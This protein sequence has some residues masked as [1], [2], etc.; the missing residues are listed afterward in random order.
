MAT[1]KTLIDE[2]TFHLLKQQKNDNETGYNKGFNG[3]NLKNERNSV[4]R[5]A[6]LLKEKIIDFE[7]K[8]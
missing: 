1:A 3:T 7:N 5:K 6:M 4:V 8:S 2:I